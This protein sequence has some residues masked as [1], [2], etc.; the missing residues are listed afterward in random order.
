MPLSVSVGLSRKALRDYQSAGFSINLTAEL[1]ASVLG[2]PDEF[3]RQ[4]A[5][6]YARAEAALD[7]QSASK[8]FPPPPPGRSAPCA[9]RPAPSVGTA[10]NDDDPRA[11]DAGCNGNGRPGGAGGG[12]MSTP[13]R[14]AILAVATRLGIDPHQECLDVLGCDLDELSLRQASEL[15][16]YFGSRRRRQSSQGSADR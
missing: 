10:S 8:S 14:R 16:D 1:D 9:G 13:Q 11:E 3:Q 5:D 12:P 15:I 2:R 7:R 6:L 4:V